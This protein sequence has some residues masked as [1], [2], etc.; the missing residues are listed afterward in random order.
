M[1]DRFVGMYMADFLQLLYELDSR[2][3]LVKWR[4]LIWKEMQ[5]LDSKGLL[6]VNRNSAW[7]QF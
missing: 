3:S 1:M 6:S 2:V 5:V 4:S 7:P